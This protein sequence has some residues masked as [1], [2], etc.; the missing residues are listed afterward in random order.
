M[1]TSNPRRW[2]LLDEKVYSY[3][4]FLLPLTGQ[5]QCVTGGNAI[6]SAQQPQNLRSSPSV[7]FS[8]R[9]IRPV[10][11]H[12]RMLVTVVR[13]SW[14]CLVGHNARL[15]SGVFVHREVSRSFS[16]HDHIRSQSDTLVEAVFTFSLCQ[17]AIQKPAHSAESLRGRSVA[18]LDS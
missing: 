16:E 2:A 4:E 17:Q 11:G 7:L 13:S 1:E 9:F 8:V 14:K 6:E 3:R 5:R 10:Q 12:E 15:E 18:E